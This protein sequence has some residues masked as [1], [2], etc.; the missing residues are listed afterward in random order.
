MLFVYWYVVILGI[1]GEVVILRNPRPVCTTLCCDESLWHVAAATVLL[2]MGIPGVWTNDV[3]S[4]GR[5]VV[6]RARRPRRC[7][8]LPCAP[9]PEVGVA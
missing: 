9:Q 8:K 7:W 2:G 3:V 6:A 5:R 4:R 1:R